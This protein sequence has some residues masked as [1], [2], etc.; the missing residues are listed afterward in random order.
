M[1]FLAFY[2][3]VY[4]LFANTLKGNNRTKAGRTGKEERTLCG[5]WK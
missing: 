1:L 2:V 3:S 4:P 5:D